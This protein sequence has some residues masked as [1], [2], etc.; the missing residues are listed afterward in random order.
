MKTLHKWTIKINDGY[1]EYEYVL[2][3]RNEEVSIHDLYEL[4]RAKL[5]ADRVDGKFVD[6]KIGS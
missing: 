4:I 3:A 2:K 5:E 1:C 6:R